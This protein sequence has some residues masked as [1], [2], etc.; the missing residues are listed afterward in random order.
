MKIIFLRILHSHDLH[1]LH[2]MVGVVERLAE[3]SDCQEDLRLLG[4]IPLLLGLLRC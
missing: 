3:F 1:L 2:R 4:G